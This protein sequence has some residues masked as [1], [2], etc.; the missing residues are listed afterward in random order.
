MVNKYQ[1]AFDHEVNLDMF[2]PFNPLHVSSLGSVITLVIRGN[3]EEVKA[4]LQTF[5]PLFI[6]VLNVNFEELFIY[7]LE[8]HG[9]LYE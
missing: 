1:M 8:N 5:N 6:D 9:D 7:E 2:K 4:Q 3:L